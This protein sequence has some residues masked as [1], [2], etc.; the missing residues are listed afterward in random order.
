VSLGTG[1]EHLGQHP[2][3][4]TLGG[5]EAQLNR[6]FGFLRF[7]RDHHD[8]TYFPTRGSH[9]QL[10]SSYSLDGELREFGEEE[11]RQ[12]LR[13]NIMLAVRYDRVLPLHRRW[14]LDLRAGLGVVNYREQHLLNLFYL[15]RE[16]P[17][18][19]RTFEVYGLQLMEQPAS[20]FGYGGVQ[21]RAEVGRRNFIGLGYNLGYY[22][23]SEYGFISEGGSFQRPETEGR[24]QG[25]GLEL[26]SLTTL[27][28][29][30]LTAE[31]NPD[32]RRMN[33]SFYAGYRF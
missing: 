18:Q 3:F 6:W 27:G 9:F 33:Y 7:T 10:W 26:G 23:L 20:G 12:N 31:Y 4:L 17:G 15:G 32:R 19:P 30:R 14:W 29:L 8:R 25:F 16:M 1:L 2:V 22:V 11:V 28:P 24:F 21:V 5:G 13:D